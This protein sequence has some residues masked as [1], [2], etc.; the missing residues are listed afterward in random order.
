MKLYRSM[1]SR[2]AHRH[3][4]NSEALRLKWVD[5]LNAISN[6]WEDLEFLSVLEGVR[7]CM[8]TPI[9][10]ARYM[11]RLTW[12]MNNGLKIKIIRSV[13][14]WEGF[15]NRYEEGD[16]FYVTAVA[17]N[18]SYLD[19]SE[20]HLG[21]PECCQTFFNACWPTVTDPIWQ[22]AVGPNKPDSNI[23][24]VL[25]NPYSDPTLRYA[26]VRFSP[27]IPCNPMCP[28]SIEL[29]QKFAALMKPELRDARLELL[30]EP[31]SWDCYRSM[32]IVKTEPF[33]LVVGSVPAA[34]RYVV[35]V[36]SH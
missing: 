32:A 35:N 23:V 13:K 16:D 24:Q 28:A 9:A 17:R 27:H 34:E 8:Q 11:E 19:E 4:W 30:S 1:P 36:V 14:R 5:R 33:R 31:H 18:A 20:K 7:D 2:N 25:A 12:A 26:S 29:G 3:V 21:Y 10:K 6:E 22:W 15:A